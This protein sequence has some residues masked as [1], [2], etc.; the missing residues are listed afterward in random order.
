[1][2]HGTVFC[3]EI[4]LPEMANHERMSM[5]LESP[6]PIACSP[7][8]RFFVCLNICHSTFRLLQQLE[9]SEWNQERQNLSVQRY[10]SPV[11]KGYLLQ[12]TFKGSRNTFL[13]QRSDFWVTKI[14]NQIE[15]RGYSRNRA[16]NSIYR[17]IKLID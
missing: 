7:V 9:T 3:L 10:L 14:D 4:S 13:W 5:D 11:N 15:L 1:M 8:F 2:S 16:K 6:A 17:S 12:G